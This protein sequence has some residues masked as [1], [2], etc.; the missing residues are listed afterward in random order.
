MVV[1]STTMETLFKE[2]I[3]IITKNIIKDIIELLKYNFV[4]YFQNQKQK[5]H[6]LFAL[7]VRLYLCHFHPLLI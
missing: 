5:H 4:L 2:Y 7:Q 6:T 3:P 1:L